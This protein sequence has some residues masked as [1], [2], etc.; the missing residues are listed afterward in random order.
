MKRTMKKRTSLLEQ[1]TPVRGDRKAVV[2]SEY[3]REFATITNLINTGDNTKAPS[4][5]RTG[6][7]PSLDS[8]EDFLAV[9]SIFPSR[10]VTL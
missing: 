4:S 10:G 2:V 3:L 9:H 7:M 6:L 8:S 5:S 1:R